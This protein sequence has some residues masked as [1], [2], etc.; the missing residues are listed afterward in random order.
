VH[1]SLPWTEFALASKITAQKTEYNP[2]FLCSE[3]GANCLYE[4]WLAG[5]DALPI[6]Q[7]YVPSVFLYYCLLPTSKTYSLD[8]YR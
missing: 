2:I 8:L 4:L 3:K 1:A 6:S 7:A 5:L